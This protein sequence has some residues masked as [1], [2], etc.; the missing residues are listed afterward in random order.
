MVLAADGPA[1]GLIESYR[2]QGYLIEAR[3]GLRKA[4]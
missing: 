4:S 3:A 2:R 1:D